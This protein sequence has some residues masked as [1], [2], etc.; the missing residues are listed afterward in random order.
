[1]K[2]YKLGLIVGRFQMLHLGHVDMISKALD[3]CERVILFIGSAQE[4]RTAKNPLTFD[5]RKKMLSKTFPENNLLILP[6]PD[7][8]IG[9]NAN[10]GDYILSQIPS[11]YGIPDIT[12]SGR[13][14]RRSTWFDNQNIAELF[15]AKEIEISAT[16]MRDFLK[17][18]NKF[19]WIEYSPCEIQN[20]YNKLRKIILD[21]QNVNTTESI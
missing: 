6:L 8:G 18:D 11:E 21:T 19:A 9:N 14:S 20:M 2:P 16:E 15:V 5:E 3:I 17:N 12:I 10:W 7:A 1:M 13:E 4:S